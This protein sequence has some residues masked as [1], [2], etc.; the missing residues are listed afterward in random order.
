MNYLN[1]F[2]AI[3]LI[4]FQIFLPPFANSS[5]YNPQVAEM[6]SEANPHRWMGWIR[7]LSGA[8]PIQT[9]DG[10][11]KIM[12]R[13]SLVMFEP[14]EK[15]SAFDYLI[16]ELHRLGFVE[17]QDFQIHNY[18]FPYGDRYPQ[19]NWKNIILSFQGD[20]PKLKDEHVLFVAHM[21][22][23]SDNE[24]L[25][26]PGA[27]DN[28]SG[29]AGLLEAAS[30]LQHYR[31]RR[32]I[33]LIWFSGEEKS[34]IG[35]TS[36]VEDYADW[37]PNIVGVVNMDMFAFDGDGDGCFEVHAG[38][39]PGSQEIGN[40]IG[41]V[42]EA[43]DLGLTYDFLDDENAYPFSDHDP[44][45]RNGVPG[46]LMMENSFYHPDETC[47]KSDRNYNYHRTS[48]TMSYIN[49]DTGFSILQAGIAA[50]AHLAQPLPPKLTGAI[51]ISIPGKASQ[52]D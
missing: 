37:L 52:L 44:F 27:D 40:L 38:T 1:S 26:A 43:Y 21:D 34:R 48:D 39:L 24:Y 17:G 7:A 47:G 33:D 8:D 15:P 6:L 36:F 32:T 16:E 3:S 51:D 11:K 49:S 14:D 18:G 12:T 28:A 31:F 50:V 41:L 45:W 20:D 23:T 13:S 30:I 42:I 4:L 9:A 29:T 46:V 35:S 5:V 19:R 25:I 22:S 2:M 10:L